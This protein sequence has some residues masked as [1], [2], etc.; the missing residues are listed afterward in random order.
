M[1]TI[2]HGAQRPTTT[3]RH[4]FVGLWKVAVFPFDATIA[5]GAIGRTFRIMAA[6]GCGNGSRHSGGTISTHLT[7]RLHSL[8]PRLE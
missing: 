6:Q 4:N 2:S 1:T 7:R 3:Y 8:R 5:T